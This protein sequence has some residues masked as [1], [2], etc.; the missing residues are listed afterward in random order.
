MLWLILLTCTVPTTC[1][2]VGSGEAPRHCWD[3]QLNT[4][5]MQ[6]AGSLLPNTGSVCETCAH[7]G[8]V[9]VCEGQDIK[10]TQAQTGKQ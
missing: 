10:G 4:G 1:V 9:P 5:I 7:K 6:L 8:R 2:C 3:K